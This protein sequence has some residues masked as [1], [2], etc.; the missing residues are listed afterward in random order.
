LKTETKHQIDEAVLANAA[1]MQ[2]DRSPEPS[3][4]QTRLLLLEL[5]EGRVKLIATVREKQ[6]EEV[7]QLLN[8]ATEIHMQLWSL[9]AHG[10][11]PGDEAFAGSVLGLMEMQTRRIQAA[12]AT[13]IP[14][15]IWLALYFNAVMSMIVVGYQAGLT[16]RRS[17]VATISL[18]LAFSAVM[19][20]IMDL[21]RPLQSLFEVDVAVMQQL[22]DFMRT[23]L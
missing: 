15:I 22:A 4:T 2:V 13:R 9:G 5:V 6:Q 8:R 12:L 3:R 7:L 11:V 18:A 1:F 14:I 21:D 20:L 23:K 17:P 16:E 10:S 19:M